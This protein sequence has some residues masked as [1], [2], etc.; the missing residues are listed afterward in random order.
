MNEIKNNILIRFCD[1]ISVTDDQAGLRIKVRLNPE[2]NSK[3]IDELPYC[4]PLL[5]KHLHINPKIGECVMV[6]LSTL[7][8]PNSFRFFIGPLISQD[9]FLNFDAFY[10]QSRC[11]L[12]G[13]N[14]ATPLPKPEMN[15]ENDGSLPNREDIAIR[16]R[17]NTDIIL[18]DNEIR[19]RCGF[20]KEPSGTPKNT[21]LFNREDLAYIQ[22]RYEKNM[23]GKNFTDY[24]S[25][26][27]I[28]ADRINL[29]SHDSKDNFTLNN[30]KDLITN[31][32]Q[33]KIE[34]QA[35]PLV[36]G[37]ELIDYLQQLIQ[38]IRTHTHSFPMSP[39]S[40]STPQLKV[41]ETPLENMLSKSIKIN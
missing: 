15:P 13:G 16:G 34:H 38:V 2:D 17:K 18:K 35:H 36:Y 28:V 24:N 29:L 3:S 31:D 30:T 19:L 1:V 33:T 20:K 39:S 7:G 9:Y 12:T 8:S 23:Q 10:Y 32:E 21:L 27:N 4:F 25:C 40:F 22:M 5:P 37:D 11:L 41:L 26:I 14:S 6:F